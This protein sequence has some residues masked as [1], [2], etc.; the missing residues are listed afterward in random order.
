MKILYA[1]SE[2]AP[3]I[4]TGG[5]AD[6][7]GSLPAALNHIGMDCR[8]IVPGYP[9]VLAKTDNLQ[10]VS[11]LQLDGS[12]VTLL[13]GE[14]GPHQV[15]IYVVD[16]PR[17]F[18]RPGNP[19]LTPE[20]YN[21]PDNA[22]RFLLFC[23]AAVLVA[24]D[25][26]GLDWRPD[27]VHANDWQTGLIAPLLQSE[28]KRP[29]TLFTIHN[30]AYQGLF[31]WATFLR[32]GLDKSLW[33]HHALEFHDQLSFIKGGIAL[34]DRV[35]TVSPTYAEEI[36][37]AEFG[38]GLEGLLQ[39]R[40]SHFSGVLNGIDYHQW[41]PL[42][43]PH[44]DTPYSIDNFPAKRNN[45]L[46]LQREFG[47]PEDEYIPL[48]GYVG[49]LVDQKGVDLILQV[50]PGLMDSGAQ[51]V[52]LGSGDHSLQSALEKISNRYHSRVGITIGYDEGL[53]HRIE[54]GS[55]CFLMPSRFEPCGLNQMY[56]LR[57]GTVPIVRRTG[58]LADSVVDVTPHTLANGTATGFV[59]DNADGSSLW[60][61]IEHAINFYRRSGSDWDILA[62]TGMQQDLSWEASAQ[63][64]LEL[65]QTSIDDPGL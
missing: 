59:F 6:V 27:V 40:A 5:L 1:S 26:A 10:K 12:T 53:S 63:H 64:Y 49:R 54:A 7:A 4:K 62:M 21:W 8:L 43:D 36:K 25:R 42:N 65:Y 18:E 39:Y 55:D 32:L 50:L 11:E 57:Y 28:Q 29:A 60:G 51:L 17:W 23:Q 35:N 34:S 33:T 38:Y 52:L 3:L 2:V 46:A 30:L 20:G 9:Q 22:D 61:A 58:G 45:K 16:A 24:L 44:I 41:D 47:L 14:C 37:T 56:S 13:Q 31:D 19:Y 48:F 15:P